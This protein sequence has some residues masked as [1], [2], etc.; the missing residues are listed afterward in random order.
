MNKIEIVKK[1]LSNSKSSNA[2]LSA[3][4]MAQASGVDLNKVPGICQWYSLELTGPCMARLLDLNLD[5]NQAVDD[6]GDTGMDEVLSLFIDSCELGNDNHASIVNHVLAQLEPPP[7]I[8]RLR[9]L[10]EL[11]GRLQGSPGEDRWSDRIRK[12][13][14]YRKLRNWCLGRSFEMTAPVSKVE[15]ND[16]DEDKW[17]EFIDFFGVDDDVKD[18]WSPF[19]ATGVSIVFSDQTTL[20]VGASGLGFPVYN[21][22]LED[23]DVAGK[24]LHFNLEEMARLPSKLI[25][26]RHSYYPL[27]SNDSDIERFCFVV[28]L[29]FCTYRLTIKIVKSFERSE[30]LYDLYVDREVLMDSE[31]VLQCVIEPFNGVD[32]DTFW[33][34]HVECF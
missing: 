2:H 5:L 7:D 26:C 8:N 6:D 31:R 24:K 1:L 3:L 22:Y 4:E 20:T 12:H 14:L 19:G 21:D 33:E 23:E 30:G 17:V 9:A 29:C 16:S 34:E 11:K 13:V 28:R 18:P 27:K 15:D 25:N 32:Y 10:K